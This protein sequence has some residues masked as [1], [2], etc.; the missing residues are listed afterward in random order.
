MAPADIGIGMIGYGFMGKAHSIGWRDIAIAA[1]AGVPRPEMTLICGR[2]AAA[3]EAAGR[4]YGWKRTTTSW[5]ELVDDPE[6]LVIDNVAP[7][8]LHHDVAVAAAEAGK[9]IYCEKPLT[10]N[11]DESLRAWKAVEA[12]GVVHMCAYLLRFFP[13]VQLAREIIASG[14]LGT[15]RHWRSNFLLSFGLPDNRRKS[16][17]DEG[18]NGYGALGDIGS[19]HIDL[20]RFLLEADPARVVGH[21][22]QV[23]EKDVTGA[24]VETDDLFAAMI[25]FDNGA[26]GVFE[27]SRVAGAHLVTNRIEIDGSRGSLS[28]SLQRLN[29]LQLTG[30]DHESRTIPVIR[31][32]DPYQSYWFPPGHP[33]GWSNAVS[34]EAAHFLGAVGGLNEIAPLGATFRDGYRCDEVIG[35][36]ARSA[37]EGRFIDVAYRD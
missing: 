33:I 7:N 22:R 20:S 25:E 5:Q 11:A 28:F 21:V 26:F 32:G 6:V 35:A 1:P 3:A 14:E 29:E 27:A 4:R 16:W 15:I 19:H 13:A 36:I 37:S 12:A 30:P 24:S 9:H 31:A 18:A 17:R 2:D 8:T 10:P 23:V 34:H